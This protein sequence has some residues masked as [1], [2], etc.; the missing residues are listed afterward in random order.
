MESGG[1]ISSLE[2]YDPFLASITQHR[3]HWYD[4][5]LCCVYRHHTD[6]HCGC[7]WTRGCYHRRRHLCHCRRC[8]QVL[9]ILFIKAVYPVNDLLTCYVTISISSNANCA[10]SCP[11]KWYEWT[12]WA[13]NVTVSQPKTKIQIFGCRHHCN[14]GEL[15]SLISRGYYD[16][17][18][19][20]FIYI[21]L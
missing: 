8:P 5:R 17:I 11:I 3:R 13:S 18:T 2:S 19:T 6:N 21:Y 7:R 15:T 10:C 9:S 12:D 1:A 16:F 20:S 4:E 14:T